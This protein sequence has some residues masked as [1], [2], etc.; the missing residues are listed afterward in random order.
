MTNKLTIDEF[1]AHKQVMETAIA[2]YVNDRMY[3]FRKLT[4]YSPKSIDISL[5]DVSTLGVENT[6][7]I[8]NFVHSEIDL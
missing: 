3:E 5:I 6:E 1:K 4:G 2:H 7:Y 8:I